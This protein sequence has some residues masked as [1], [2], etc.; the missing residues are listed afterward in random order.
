M[1]V[2]YLIGRI[3]LVVLPL[4][5][6]WGCAPSQ[7][8]KTSHLSHCDQM[9]ERVHLENRIETLNYLSAAFYLGCHEKV[10][11][12]GTRAQ[13]E[14][15]YKTFSILKETTEIF[16]PE[17]TITDYILESYERGYLSLMIALSYHKLGE[18]E[19]TAVELRKLNN[20]V[21]SKLYNYG[22]DPINLLFQAVLWD[23]LGDQSES[24][25]DWHR[26][27]D[28]G[29]VHESLGQFASRQV[30][31]IDSQVRSKRE[32]KIYSIGQFPDIIWNLE[33]INAK[34]GYFSVKPKKDFLN[35]CFSST[36]LRISTIDW[37]NKIAIRHSNGYHPLINAKSWIRLPVGLIYS[38]M[39]F[40]SGATI[41]ISGCAADAYIEGD[42]TLCRVAIQGGTALIAKSPEVLEFTLKP[43]LRHWNTVPEAFLFT[44]TEDIKKEKCRPGFGYQSFIRRML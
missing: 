8:L 34:N 23:Q 35:N 3:P 22:E 37:F 41:L 9:D 12:Y 5:L 6:F 36:G 38:I 31:M 18:N 11:E 43:D 15:K 2:G 14:Y 28:K 7:H 19:S 1:A 25:V 39:T 24:R 20:E 33:F 13:T 21:I 16:L 17:G 42:G 44:T 26:L 4:L 32:W 29:N 40:S 27:E 30:Q 10:I